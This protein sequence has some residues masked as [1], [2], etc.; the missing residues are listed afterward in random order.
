MQSRW[1]E[2]ERA[3]L[4]NDPLQAVIVGADS[5]NS[6]T[7]QGSSHA[8]LSKKLTE[9]LNARWLREG[10]GTTWSRGDTVQFHF[11]MVNIAGGHAA[12]IRWQDDAT[13]SN[14]FTT[15]ASVGGRRIE[16]DFPANMTFYERA[17][18]GS[19]MTDRDLIDYGYKTDTLIIPEDDT[20]PFMR[21]AGGIDVPVSQIEFEEDLGVVNTSSIDTERTN[22]TG[23]GLPEQGEGISLP[24]STVAAWNISATDVDESLTAYNFE[25]QQEHRGENID[26]IRLS[27]MYILGQ[28]SSP[29]ATANHSAW[30][31]RTA[32]QHPHTTRRLIDKRAVE[33]P[34]QC[35]PG[36]P[37]KDGACCNKDGKCGFKD[38]HCG[39]DVCLSNCSSKGMV[40]LT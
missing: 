40:N 12:Y 24:N 10:R 29:N 34:I 8:A 30:N 26:I 15:I 31:G 5:V 22:V 1:Q 37:C 6:T 25:T 13:G 16:N 4:V 35:G 3:R 23:H 33:G 9:L 28:L 21:L 39:P 7:R 20:E 27:E 18:L 32:S 2:V 38:V 19:S 36:Q 14:D 17:A 11:R